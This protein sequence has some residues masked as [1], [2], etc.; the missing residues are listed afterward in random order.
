M[1]GII[2]RPEFRDESSVSPALNF[3]GEL[4]WPGELPKPVIHR[5]PEELGIPRIV[6]ARAVVSKALLPQ[7][8]SVPLSRAERADLCHVQRRRAEAALAARVPATQLGVD[9]AVPTT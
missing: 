8:L 3:Y 7:R 5:T 6:A 2:E 1:D 4:V 9:R